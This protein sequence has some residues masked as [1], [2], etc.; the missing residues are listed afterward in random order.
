[1]FPACS[2]DNSC[3]IVTGQLGQL[4]VSVCAEGTEEIRPMC[5]VIVA[6]ATRQIRSSAVIHL[7]SNND[8]SCLGNAANP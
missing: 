4:Q 5:F 3:V 2:C 8:N 1:M 7:F 6:N